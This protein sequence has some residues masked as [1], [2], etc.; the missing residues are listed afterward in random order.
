MIQCQH[1]QVSHPAEFILNGRWAGVQPS[2]VFCVVKKERIHEYFSLGPFQNHVFYWHTA[3]HKRDFGEM[4]SWA[5][6][7][8]DSMY[9]FHGYDR[10]KRSTYLENLWPL[11]RFP[12]RIFHLQPFISSKRCMPNVGPKPINQ[13][14]EE[15]TEGGN[16]R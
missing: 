6:D 7:L 2:A 10:M 1:V 16:L 5:T 9:V 12:S 13:S 11:W 14:T 4:E 15:L 8:L 3:E